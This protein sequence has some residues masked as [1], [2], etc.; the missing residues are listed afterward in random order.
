M[1]QLYLLRHGHSTD[2]GVGYTDKQRELSSI[3]MLQCHSVGRFLA[4]RSFP[5]ELI[6]TSDAQ[7]ALATTSLITSHLN[8]SNESI[9]HEP[10]LYQTSIP[11][12]LELLHLH[13]SFQHIIIVGHNPT[14]SY[15][16]EHFTSENIGEIPPGTLLILRGSFS[17]WRN[18]SKGN[19]QLVEKFIPD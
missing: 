2:K 5:I 7:R 17:S 3:G 13:D 11:A 19:M 14:L 1:K 16:A 18:M 8:I 12:M 4:S 9:L 15:F 6:L 10:N